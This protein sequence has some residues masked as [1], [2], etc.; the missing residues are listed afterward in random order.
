MFPLYWNWA[1]NTSPSVYLALWRLAVPE[2]FVQ[3][4]EN[5]FREAMNDGAF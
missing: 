5:A 1:I 3:K 2:P 4:L